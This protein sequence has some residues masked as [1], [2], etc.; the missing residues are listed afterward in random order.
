MNQ[1]DADATIELLR[2]ISGKQL[3]GLLVDLAIKVESESA[4]GTISRSLLAV[5]SEIYAA[6]RTR[7]WD[8][9]RLAEAFFVLGKCSDATNATEVQKLA[10]LLSPSIGEAHLARQIFIALENFVDKGLVLDRK[11]A[12]ELISIIH[13]NPNVWGQDL[14]L[15]RRVVEIL[16]KVG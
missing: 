8:E 3:A 16:T 15:Q 9:P 6:I 2:N 10:I 4:G 5:I 12:H 1:K 7:R 14:S 13:G 11:H